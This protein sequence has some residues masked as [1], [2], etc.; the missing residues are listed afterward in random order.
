[1]LT[2]C[3]SFNEGAVVSENIDE[4]SIILL[5]LTRYNTY[6]V[7]MYTDNLCG[8]VCNMSHL[9]MLTNCG[10]F[11]EGAVVSGN[12]A[13]TSIIRCNTHQAERHTDQVVTCALC[14]TFFDVH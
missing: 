4:T 13:E 9:L 10:R 2:N 14:A 8:Q 7:Q 6:Q 1:M 11:N 12:H 5:L 3:G